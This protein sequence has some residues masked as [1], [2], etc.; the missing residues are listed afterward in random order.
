MRQKLKRA[1]PET[2]DNLKGLMDN[3][4]EGLIEKL[5]VLGRHTFERIWQE[6]QDVNRFKTMVNDYGSFV[7]ELLKK[8]VP[9]DMCRAIKQLNKRADELCG[10]PADCNGQDFNGKEWLSGQQI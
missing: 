5:Q 9:S 3:Q 10:M 7:N 4:A 8:G 6:N 2:A 1:I